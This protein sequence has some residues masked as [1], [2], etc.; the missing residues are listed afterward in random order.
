MAETDEDDDDDEQILLLLLKSDKA[1]ALQKAQQNEEEDGGEEDDNDVKGDQENKGVEAWLSS[2]C[3]RDCHACCIFLGNAFECSCL[4]RHTPN[5]FAH[6]IHVTLQTYF[7][8]TNDSNNV[9]CA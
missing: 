8:N 3:C 9:L 1:E 5:K 7:T 6:F 2:V 4:G